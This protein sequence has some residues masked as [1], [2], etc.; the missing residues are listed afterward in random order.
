MS[1]PSEVQSRPRRKF[2]IFR[3]VRSK[4]SAVLVL[5]A[6]GITLFGY[7]TYGLLMQVSGH[8]TELNDE[9]LPDLEVSQ[10]ITLAADMAKDSM[11]T[12]LVVDNA[13]GIDQAMGEVDA[14]RTALGSA[15]AELND[16]IEPQFSASLDEVSQALA[17]LAEARRVTFASDD[18]I[19][20]RVR[21]MQS[22]I[23]E[24]SVV[25]AELSRSAAIELRQGAEATDQKID[26]TVTRL[27]EVDFYNQSLLLEAQAE[28]NLLTGAAVSAGG[29]KDPETLAQIEAMAEKSRDRLLEIT[30]IIS[31]RAPEIFDTSLLITAVFTLETVLAQSLFPSETLRKAAL[32][33]RADTAKAIDTAINAQMRSLLASVNAAKDANGEA[34]ELLLTNEVGFLRELVEIGIA[35]NMFQVAALDAATSDDEA[36]VSDA[37]KGMVEAGAL[38]AKYQDFRD[39]RVVE[40]LS[41]L[42]DLNDPETGLAALQIKGIKA[43]EA[44]DAATLNARTSVEAISQRAAEFTASTLSEIDVMT[45]E[46]FDEVELMVRD[47]VVSAAVAGVCFLAIFAAIQL[48]ILRPLNR[49]SASTERL[50]EGD[51]SPVTGFERTST[52]IY[53][54]ARSLSVFRD[55]IVEKE[56]LEEMAAAE[57]QERERV[58]AKAVEALGTGLERLSS[59]DLTGHIHEELGEGYDR[60]RLDFNRTLDTLNDT[61]GQVIDTSASIRNGASEISQASQDLSHRTESQ[62]ATLE[63]TAAALDEMTASVTS[64]AEGARDVE[65]TSN[66]A[67]SEAEASGDIVRSAVS[68][69]TEIEQSSGKIAQI[70]SVID[71]IAFQTNLL[72]L[73]AGVEAARAGEAGRGFAVVASE[74]RGLA[75]RSSDAALEIKN[76]ISDSSKQVE[77]GVDLVGKAGEALD[78]ILNRVSH[79]SELISG[80]A[81][82]AQEQS[83]G[84]LEI[85]TGMNQLDQVTQQNAAMVEEATAASQLLNTDAETLA[86]LVARFQTAN[87]ARTPAAGAGDVGEDAGSEALAPT[88]W[89]DAQDIEW[90]AT[91]VEEP[92]VPEQTDW[93]DFDGDD[94]QATGT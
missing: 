16:E 60:L 73:N 35:I 85:N 12:M 59:G 21:D 58:Q 4:L 37:E 74:V 33:A 51:R 39:G 38:F 32:S 84:L 82:G 68:A 76:L 47:L 67:R 31:E 92:F 17:D 34:L 77:R 72:A 54:I 30:D 48:L 1:D 43:A 61:V 69:M 57:R 87:T 50:A 71:D 29:T 88:S 9:N 36:S 42:S 86:D 53:R 89:G 65:R 19:E 75:Q 70:I 20:A 81:T 55:G 80:I 10:D 45:D 2:G 79:V 5:L 27:V 15:I 64:A 40:F 28:L 18:Q 6:A 91:E 22:I 52:E 13:A 7:I 23:S 94:T 26:N 90:E 14:A 62:A 78:N 44:S 56:E 93:S 24:L 3:S 46:I 49:I 63:E 11:I 25:M 66:E 8:I 83:T 41:R